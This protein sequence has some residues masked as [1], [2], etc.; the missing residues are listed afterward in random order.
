MAYMELTFSMLKV[1]NETL[2]ETLGVIH[3]LFLIEHLY[4]SGVW[5]GEDWR[6]SNIIKDTCAK[7][8][9]LCIQI[10]LTTLCSIVNQCPGDFLGHNW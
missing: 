3:L 9:G 6:M 2:S 10:L 5:F 8:I 4:L 7:E 1:Y